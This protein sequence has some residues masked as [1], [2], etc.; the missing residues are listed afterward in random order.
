MLEF[1]TSFTHH[2]SI[3]SGWLYIPQHAQ[4]GHTPSHTYQ[5]AAWST[6]PLIQS[7]IYQEGNA[8]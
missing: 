1:N 4:K 8:F 5:L 7:A 6:D 2:A 3:T